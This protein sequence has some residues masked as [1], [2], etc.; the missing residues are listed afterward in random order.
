MQ[1]QAFASRADFQ[2]L[3]V[4]ALSWAAEAGLRELHAW[5][6]SFVDWPLS[7]ARVLEALTAW[8]GP[9][10]QLHLLALQYDD[11]VRRHPRFVRWRRDFAHCVTARAVEPE[12]RLEAAPESLLLGLGG[13]M[14]LS[15]KLFDRHLWRGEL[16][17][18]AAHRQRGLEWFDALA[19]RSSD[20]FAPTTLGL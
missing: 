13:D 10:R 12:L 1:A 4:E 9:G 18:D 5:D 7:D 15:L 19:Q 17:L 6:A 8:A 2:G 11:V 14:S 20:S 3:L 16:S